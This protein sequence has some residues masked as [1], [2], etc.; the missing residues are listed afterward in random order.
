MKNQLK[1]VESRDEIKHNLMNISGTSPALNG[2]I[3]RFL[4]AYT[5]QIKSDQQILITSSILT[6]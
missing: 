4:N 3:G 6:R 1:P 2:S 5:F